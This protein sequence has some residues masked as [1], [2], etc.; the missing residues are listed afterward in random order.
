MVKPFSPTELSARIS[1]AIRRREASEP[2]ETYSL[3]NVTIDYA[4][5][6]VTVAGQPMH[7]Y[8]MEYRTLIE[9]SANAGLVLA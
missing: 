4:D 9:L 5:R 3:R 2:Q 1:A 8:P 7:L 6:R